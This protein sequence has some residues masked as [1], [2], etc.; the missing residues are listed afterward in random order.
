MAIAH[1]Y[2]YTGNYSRNGNRFVWFIKKNKDNT[3]KI[4]YCEI[5]DQGKLS[6]AKTIKDELPSSFVSGNSA[7]TILSQHL[8]SLENE[9]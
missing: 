7:H 2:L 9:D 4:V 6:K 5:S 1:K 3:R 8:T